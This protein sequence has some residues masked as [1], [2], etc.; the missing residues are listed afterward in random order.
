[1]AKKC[2]KK[3]DISDEAAFD[4][5]KVGNSRYIDEELRHPNQTVRRRLETRS[6][7]WPFAVVVTCADSRVSPEA[8]FDQGIGDL[9]VIRVAGNV[10]SSEVVASVQYAVLSLGVE[11]VVMLGH[12]SCG[13]VSAALSPS[14]GSAP[15]EL[16]ALVDMIKASI[17]PKKRSRK[18]TDVTDKVLAEAVRKNLRHQA[19]SI[20]KALEGHG[21]KY[22]V[23]PA[24]YNLDSGRVDWL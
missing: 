4:L 22:V 11:L 21:G 23:R 12:Q 2:P 13:A 20:E 24:Y 18:K 3:N 7:Q 15:A 1:M 17:K 8:I 5:L 19:A 10:A 14:G 6:G 9:F 16:A